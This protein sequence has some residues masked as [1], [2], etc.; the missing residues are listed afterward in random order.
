MSLPPFVPLATIGERLP[1]V[2]PEGTPNRNYCIRDL[3]ARTI[4]VA[5]YIGAIEGAGREFGPVHVYRMTDEQSALTAP[6]D[7]TGYGPAVNR[8]QAIVGR[9]WY[10]DNTREPIR[11]ET[12]RDGLVAIGAVTR[13]EDLPTTSGLP[14]Y[15]L[16]A[17]FAALFDPDLQGDALAAAITAFQKAY[18]SK[19]ALARVSIMQ[20]GAAASESGLLVTFPNKETRPLAPGPSSVISK[21]VVEIFAPAFLAEPAVLWL[22]ESGNKVVLRDDRIATRLGLNI[23]ADKNLPDL[24]LA[25]LGG[26]EA[27]L[28]FV[29]VVA[30]DGAMTERR[31][32]ALLELTRAAGFADEQ[33]AFLTAYKDRESAGFRK[34][35]SQ[36][37]W[38]SCAWFM[39]EPEQ[40]VAMIDERGDT[41]RP[42]WLLGGGARE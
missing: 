35:V 32:M 27:R 5:L 41:A 30:T 13:R 34:T 17:D 4:F 31:R 14:R 10:A 23:E 29:E 25:D 3:A 26:G 15:A 38:G 9:R 37:A 8:K 33:I 18:L 40:L 11:D 12:L 1:L 36:L 22:S 24:I 21:A 2:F 6:A 19:S 39:S 16:I 20:A 28:L 42:Q 7:R